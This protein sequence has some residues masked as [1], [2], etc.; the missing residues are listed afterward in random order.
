VIPY[1]YEH[2]LLPE[3]IATINDVG[4]FLGRINKKDPSLVPKFISYGWGTLAETT[5]N[6]SH[7]NN[8][9]FKDDSINL[10]VD[11][12]TREGKMPYLIRST[13]Y[14]FLNFLIWASMLPQ[15]AD[16]IEQLRLDIAQLNVEQ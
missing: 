3:K 11:Q 13:V 10:V 8:K 5:Q 7:A 9:R 2:G 12:L 14:T 16:E 15:T 4:R 1:L 6:G